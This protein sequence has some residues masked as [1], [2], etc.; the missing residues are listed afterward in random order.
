MRLPV[1]PD[2]ACAI[3]RE[4]DRQVLQAYIMNYL[5]VG[6]LQ[7]RR[8]DGHDRDESPGSQAS[9]QRHGMLLADANVKHSLGKSPGNRGEARSIHHRGTDG[10]HALILFHQPQH[11][12]AKDLAVRG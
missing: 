1:I 9:G 11:G 5:V 2:N 6:A 4:N 3:D 10:H 12:L 8:V 7:E